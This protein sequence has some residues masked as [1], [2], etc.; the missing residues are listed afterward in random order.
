MFGFLSFTK[1]PRVIVPE[2][3]F[4]WFVEIGS[5]T[6]EEIVGPLIGFPDT[7]AKEF[8]VVSILKYR[9]KESK[10]S[11]E[12][13]LLDNSYIP[14][15][16]ENLGT[17]HTHPGFGAYLS[18]QDRRNLQKHRTERIAIVVDPVRDEANVYIKDNGEI[19]KGQLIVAEDWEVYNMFKCVIFYRDG[20]PF[21]VYVPVEMNEFGRLII[22]KHIVNRHCSDVLYGTDD[23]V[24]ENGVAYFKN[25]KMIAL[26][27]KDKVPLYYFNIRGT[28]GEW[29]DSVVVNGIIDYNF[30]KVYVI[31]GGRR[32][33]FKD[34]RS[35]EVRDGITGVHVV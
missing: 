32:W 18:E 23:L 2:S 9:A 22:R 25:P 10:T 16:L 14:A 27:Y 8:V 33:L 5:K 13:N 35:E 15:G 34:W 30:T 26:K 21:R 29:F 17:I 31:R 7:I 4:Q 12:Y 19:V 1:I 3:E 24:I 20:I 28:Y 6:D 11:V